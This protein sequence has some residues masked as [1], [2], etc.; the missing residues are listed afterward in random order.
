MGKRILASI[1]F[2][3]SLILV[4]ILLGTKKMGRIMIKKIVTV[5]SVVLGMHVCKTRNLSLSCLLSSIPFWVLLGSEIQH[6]ISLGVLFL[7]KRFFLG[8]A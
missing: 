3:G 5:L 4:R 8:F 7:F 2:F 6:G 1:L